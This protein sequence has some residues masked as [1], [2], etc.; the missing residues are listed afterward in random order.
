M[1]SK[2]L[3]KKVT[4]WIKISRLNFYPMTFIAYTL[5]SIAAYRSLKVF[6]FKIYI[7]GY[8]IIF[9]IE[10]S[11]VLTNEYYDY[12]TD[13]INKNAGFFTGGSRVLVEK[14]L[15]FK[16]IK[17]GILTVFILILVSS[18]LFF[19]FFSGSTKTIFYLITTG[20][21]LGLGYTV[22][23]IKFCYRG[24]GEVV[25]A[26]T[27]S[28]YVIL[29]GYMFQG[30]RFFDP[31]PWIISTPLFLAVFAA[32]TLA[33]IPDYEADKAVSKKSLAVIFGIPRAALI[34]LIFTI[35]AAATII[36][37]GY[38][39][40]LNSVLRILMFILILHGAILSVKILRFLM[41]GEYNIKIDKIM[42]VALS[43]IIWFGVIPLVF[44]F[45]S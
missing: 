21:F 43:Y 5:G 1:K 38:L 7:F 17:H 11:T 42:Q 44:F 37:L 8:L 15:N 14:K 23:P 27:H 3:K 39:E 40:V 13:K 16:E 6:D 18:F 29:C 45:L 41:E 34:S 4:A 24:L 9:L 22:P 32:I 2:Y 31:L 35:L 19:Q 36:F 12:Q 28:P 10:L 20:I 26:I 25:V 30:G 33:G